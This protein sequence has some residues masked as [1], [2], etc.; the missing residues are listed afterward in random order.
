MRRD[1]FERFLSCLIYAPR[2]NYT[3]E[4]RQKW[5]AILVQA[6]NGTSSEFNVYLIGIGAGAHP[7]HRAHDARRRFPT[8]DVRAVEAQLVAAARRWD[9]DLKQALVDAL[10]E[11]RGNELLPPVRRRLPGRLPRGFHRACGGARHRDD[12][13]ADRD[14][15]AGDEPLS[16]AGGAGRR[17]CASSCSIWASR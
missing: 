11:A 4:L 17:R 3:T 14:R 1:P 5:Q 13:S 6:F 12:G 15:A 9:D 16:A 10:G 8:F 2:E 7:D